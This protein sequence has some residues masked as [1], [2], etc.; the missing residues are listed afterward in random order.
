MQRSKIMRYNRPSAKTLDL[1][2]QYEVGGGEKYYNKYLSKFT[3]PGGH[4]GP[5]IAVGIDCAY[6]TSEEL[7]SMF[8]FLSKENVELVLGAI[9][10]TGIA[11][12]QY[13]P[14]LREAGIEVSWKRA[15]EIFETTTWPKYARL[16]EKAFPG[17]TEFHPDAYG[18][19][20]SIVFN[21]GTSMRG[22]SRLE[23]RNIK[24]LVMNKKYKDIA[25]EIRSMKRLWV[26]KNLD[27][28]LYRREAEASLI[29]SVA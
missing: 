21:R 24:E 16:A 3:W 8:S 10:K 18:T 22:G 26:G 27:G 13:T 5:T 25:G 28:L 4:S 29:E 2:L 12:K 1:L 19:I 11:G 15:L 9:G 6:Y 23:M 7:K 14:V 17:L 20:V